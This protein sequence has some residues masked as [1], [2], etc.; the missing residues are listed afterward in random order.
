M[1]ALL[2]RNTG[3]VGHVGRREWGALCVYWLVGGADLAAFAAVR[4]VEDMMAAMEEQ[5]S[6]HSPF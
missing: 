2:R 6:N 3:H 4:S 1:G 5:R